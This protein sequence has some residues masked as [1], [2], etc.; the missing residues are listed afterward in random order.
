MTIQE[1][2]SLRTSDLT[3]K[4]RQIDKKELNDVKNIKEVSTKYC[5]NHISSGYSWHFKRHFRG[6]ARIIILLKRKY[7]NSKGLKQ[8][9]ALAARLA[10]LTPHGS[11][12]PFF[13]LHCNTTYLF[14]NNKNKLCSGLPTLDNNSLC[15]KWGL[16][17]IPLPHFPFQISPDSSFITF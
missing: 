9:I 8:K 2:R 6:K 17:S 3:E 5:I 14:L 1:N 4:I 11:N 7:M 10:A 12:P 15:G 13:E 16:S